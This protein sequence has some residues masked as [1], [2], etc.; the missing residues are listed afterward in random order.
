M[1]IVVKVVDLDVLVQGGGLLIVL[2]DCIVRCLQ[3]QPVPSLLCGP[4]RVSNRVIV[5]VPRGYG[6]NQLSLSRQLSLEAL[7]VKD[8]ERGLF[9]ELR[10]E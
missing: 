3:T 8:L 5:Q 6:A 9:A 10:D 7:F 4:M 1:G 2:C